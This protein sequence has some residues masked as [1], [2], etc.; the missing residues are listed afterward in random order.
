MACCPVQRTMDR[1]LSSPRAPA[2]ARADS[3]LR[4]RLADGRATTAH[5]A[6]WDL[7]R[8]RVR[9]TRLA[10]QQRVVDWCA[11]TGCGDAVVG[12]FYTRPE[13]SPLG[14]LRLGGDVHPARGLHRSVAHAAGVPARRR[15]GRPDRPPR[16][17]AAADGGD[18]LQA[19]PLL[20]CEGEIVYRDGIDSEGFSVANGQFDSDITDGRHPRAAIGLADGEVLVLRRRRPFGRRRGAH[21]RRARDGDGGPRR[22]LRDESRRRRAPLA[23]SVTV[24]C[25]T[26]PAS[27][28]V[29]TSPGDVRSPP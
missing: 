12:G 21:P 17:A 9:V 20:V 11:A 26:V 16:R 4:L 1:R 5:V 19:G 18:L 14:E 7:T 10:T 8:T 28:M 2:P 22:G 3:L 6:R 29:S 25:A 24:S 13:G 15:R 23:S 27:V